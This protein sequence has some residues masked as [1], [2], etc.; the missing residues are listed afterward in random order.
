VSS[1]IPNPEGKSA[2]LQIARAAGLVT[3]AFVISNMTGLVRQILIADAFGT[4]AAMEAFNAANRI[5]ETLFNLV[6]GGAL[7]SAFIPTFAGL[8]AQDQNKNAWRLASSIANLVLIIL[9]VLAGLA[10]VF[11]PLLVRHVIAPG[12]AVDPAK[13][14][15]TISLTR[16]ML[17]SAVIFG[18][19]GLVMGILNSRNHFF[20]P[21]LTPALY[22]LGLIFGVLVLSPTLGIYG[23][24][25]GVLIGAAG[26]LLLQ[27]PLLFRQSGEYT[28]TLG[29]KSAQVREVA[30]LMGPRLLGVA[31]VQL[32]FWINVRLASRHPEGSVTAITLA[33]ALMLMPQAAIAQSIATAALPT[34]SAQ[35]ARNQLEEM[36]RSLG[37]TLRGVLLLSIP[38]S[39]GLMML[40]TPLIQLLYQR[41]AFTPESTRLVSWALLWYAAGLVGHALV[42][43]LARAFYSL[44]DTKTPVL[45][46]TAAMSLNI[47]FSF[48]FSNLF[49]RIGWMPH[50]GLALANTLAT[51]LETIGLL[52]I[53]NRRL[54]GLR[55]SRIQQGAGKAMLAAGAMAAALWTWINWSQTQPPWLIAGGG[56]LIG[57]SIYALGLTLLKTKEIQQ[58]YRMASRKLG[59]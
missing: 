23:L 32:N 6:A 18:L 19:S 55:G 7:G 29:L 38:A 24:A 13:E 34:F 30:R 47:V 33:F 15:L 42:E 49:K 2:N 56:I 11:A 3:L 52:W 1:Q 40:R 50:G 14:A 8:L 27:L 31:V 54:N 53:M 12:F 10:A 43:I 46:G 16:L 5:S 21:A 36:K 28:L 9:T 57:V 59:F 45:I 20:I 51:A 41:G 37:A 44:H 39:L 58:A 17:P 25:W 35:V 26:H 4:S 48:L 22:Q